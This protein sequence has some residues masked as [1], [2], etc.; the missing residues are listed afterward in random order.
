MTAT[1]LSLPTLR[2][3]RGGS[4][5]GERIGLAVRGEA[6]IGRFAGIDELGSEE[7]E[8]WDSFKIGFKIGF[9]AGDPELPEVEAVDNVGGSLI[10]PSPESSRL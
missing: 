8:E 7:E 10:G 6:S 3:L 2:S 9:I 1:A 4:F 5:A